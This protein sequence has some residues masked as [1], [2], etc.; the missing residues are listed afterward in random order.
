MID[1]EG[2]EYNTIFGGIKI[3]YEIGGDDF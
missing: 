2:T 1:K 3:R